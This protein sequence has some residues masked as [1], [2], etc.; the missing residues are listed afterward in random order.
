DQAAATRAIIKSRSYVDAERIGVW[1]WSGGGSMSLNAIFRYPELYHTAIA[2]AFIS[3]QRFYDTI[4]QE[5]YMGLLDDN[6][7]GFKNGSPI[8]FANQLEGNLLIVHGTGDDNCHYQSCAALINELVRHN[9][10]FSMMAYPNRSHSIS[11]G[12]GTTRHL[13]EL[14]TGYLKDHMPPGPEKSK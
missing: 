9:K 11:E 6:E 12:D 14:L 7:E 1:G 8:T 2:I 5:R 3:D 4:Y 10:Y 13:Y